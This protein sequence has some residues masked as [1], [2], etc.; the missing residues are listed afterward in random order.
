MARLA[1]VLAARQLGAG[2]D[3]MRRVGE[4]A[5]E[6]ILARDALEGRGGEPVD[7]VLMNPPYVRAARSRSDR[8]RIRRAFT[9]AKGAF[10]VHVPFVELAMRRL[11]PGGAFAIL[12]TSKLFAAEYARGLRLLLAEVTTLSRV[13]D[14]EA[15]ED[16]RSGALVEQALLIGTAQPP[17]RGHRVA[18]LRPAA[19]AEVS[20]VRAGRLW[21]YQAELLRP[22]WPAVRASPSEGRLIE[23]ICGGEV[24][25]LGSLALVRGGLRG[26]DYRRCC[27]EL[28]EGA[29]QAEAMRVLTP[30]NI[31][32]Y[33]APTQGP[34]RLAG[35]QWTEPVLPKRPEAI[36]ERLWDL[37]GRAKVVVKGVGP[38]PTAAWCPQ[39]AALLVA[40]WGVWG[41]EEL[42]WSVLGLLNSGPVAWVHSQQLAM[43]R[44][45]RGSLRTPMA[46]V[47]QLPVPRK[48]V[49]PLAEFARLRY[50]AADP[51]AQAA[52][53]ERIDE[54]A[55]RAY[56][57]TE[58]DL[59]LM[60]RTAI[61]RVQ[62]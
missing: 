19:L 41:D 54:A 48:R 5:A 2:P 51:A 61:G 58:A 46:W 50:E 52:L 25:A 22:R 45:P 53:Q 17:P 21:R 29:G 37:F 16:A 8:E 15:C 60:A 14:L 39:P 49:G 28:G 13:I 27:E 12:T 30:G 20:D 23:R 24:R 43:A 35:R 42:L 11:R 6:S 40:V 62:A 55:A 31:R 36:S 32:A 33:R 47:A 59:G 10:D 18:V 1:M 56:D 26:Y 38:R 7:C 3:E 34:L 9:T 4:A 44:I 57:L